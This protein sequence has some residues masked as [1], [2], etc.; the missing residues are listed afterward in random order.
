VRDQLDEA[1]GVLRARRGGTFIILLRNRAGTAFKGLY[2]LA[3][4]DDAS[5]TKLCLVRIAGGGPAVLQ[6]ADARAVMKFD[7]AGKRF[8]PLPTRAIDS[9]DAIALR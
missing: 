9:A 1:I 4:T 7:T 3:P 8:T 6:P 5:A 2:Q